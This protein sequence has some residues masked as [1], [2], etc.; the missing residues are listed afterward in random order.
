[1]NSIQHLLSQTGT[2]PVER[3]RYTTGISALDSLLQGG[4]LAGQTLEFFGPQSAG[5]SGTVLN[6][7]THLQIAG[8][9]V[10]WIDV[11][12]S[13]MP[14]NLT[15]QHTGHLWV[16]HPPKPSD[17]LF[18]A[19]VMIRSQSF[20]MVVLDGSCLPSPKQSI[21][22]QRFARQS[23]THLVVLRNSDTHRST[24]SVTTRLEFKPT[25]HLPEDAL[26]RRHP[27]SWQVDITHRGTSSPGQSQSIQLLES[28]HICRPPS[29]LRPDRSTRHT[30]SNRR[31]KS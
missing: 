3:P 15:A 13:L 22:L 28:P 7:I 17:A 1:M 18:C 24:P 10:V 19:E 11:D 2:S 16:I 25:V 29:V 6:A 4:L 27:F 8:H 31:T 26:T 23:G 12:K 5:K 30:S 14:M 21:R 9:S 20:A